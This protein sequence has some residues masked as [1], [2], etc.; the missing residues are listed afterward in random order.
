MRD[1]DKS[2]GDSG[3]DPPEALKPLSMYKVKIQ[4]RDTKVAVYV[5]D[6]QVC[7]AARQDRAVYKKAIV[8][9][10]DPCVHACC[11]IP[12]ED[13]ILLRTFVVFAWE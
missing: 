9:A 4:L 11:D 8:Y 3:C 12:V 10:A 7:T 2:N 6:E 1:G 5:N 13:V